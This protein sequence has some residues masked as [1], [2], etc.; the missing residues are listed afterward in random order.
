MKCPNCGE[1][2]WFVRSG[3]CPFCKTP[4]AATPKREPLDQPV[5]PASQTADNVQ[6]AKKQCAYCG[7]ENE[8]SRTHCRECGTSEFKAIQVSVCT[9]SP[10]NSPAQ[11]STPGATRSLTPAKPPPILS[12]GAS[13][14]KKQCHK[15]GQDRPASEEFCPFCTS[16]VVTGDSPSP[17]T[18]PRIPRGDWDNVIMSGLVCGVIMAFVRAK[19]GG[20]T[21]GILIAGA[22]YMFFIRNPNFRFSG[23]QQVVATLMMLFIGTEYKLIL[24]LIAN[25]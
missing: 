6:E 4:I 3:P 13:I 17:E 20:N 25:K 2:L 15:C 16:S 22:A 8:E 14:I 12:E 10:L 7:R 5:A 11:V 23:L 19:G 24:S 18:S 9:P 21:T 1:I